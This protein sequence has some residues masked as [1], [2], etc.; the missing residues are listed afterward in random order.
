MVSYNT[1]YINGVLNRV[2]ISSCIILI[3]IPKGT[4]QISFNKIG[5][6]S[7]LDMLKYIQNGRTFQS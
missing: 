3:L 2:E 4:W 6:D 5:S 1:E 7:S